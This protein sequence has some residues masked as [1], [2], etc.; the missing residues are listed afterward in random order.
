MTRLAT[1]LRFEADQ[2]LRDTKAAHQRRFFQGVADASQPSFGGADEGRLPAGNALEGEPDKGT[3]EDAES[4]GLDQGRELALP[5]VAGPIIENNFSKRQGQIRHERD[6]MRHPSAAGFE[7]DAM[8]L[9]RKPAIR[10]EDKKQAA[11]FEDPEDF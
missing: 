1:E 9:K 8:G 3:F 11:R 7:P 2:H 4:T 10:R 6:P 5:I